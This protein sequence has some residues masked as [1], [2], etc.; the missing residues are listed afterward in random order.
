[1]TRHACAAVIAMLTV[2]TASV[3]EAGVQ[4]IPCRN[5][6]VF[7]N[8]AVNVVVLP[9]D[10]AE[11]LPDATGLGKRLSVLL[12]MEVLRSIAKFGSVGAVQMEGTPADCNPDLVIAKLLGRTPGAAATVAKGQGLIVV[13]GRFYSQGGDVFVQT[14]CR[15]MRS[16]IEE[17]FDV[18]MGGH[19]FSAAISAPVFACASWKVTKADLDNFESQFRKSTILRVKPEEAASGSPLPTQ[20]LPYWI[21]DT[22]GDWM[23]IS[24]QNGPQG[25]IQLSGARD[26]WSLARWLP[27]LR[28]VEGIAGYL[29]FRI[30]AQ[31]SAPVRPE[32]I[33][34]AMQAFLD[35]EASV[36]A[37][38]KDGTAGPAAALRNALAGAVQ[39]QLRGILSAAKPGATSDDRANALKFFERAE[40]ML[41]TDGNAR[42]LKAVAQVLLIGSG[43]PGV[44]LRQTAEDLLRAVSADPGNVRLLANLQ[45]AYEIL[46]AQAAPPLTDAER[47]GMEERLAAIK[48]IRTA[49]R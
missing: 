37:F 27:E 15:F 44:P 13:W 24:I 31:Q 22:Q 48:Q 29:R 33:A 16:G 14:Y 21:T 34:G 8:A 35:Y 32:W 9:Y 3:A 25:W 23:K 18:S 36:A 41:P 10:S 20:P 26:T 7:K 49:K 6:F 2:C 39:L 45:S 28:Y 43:S 11:A 4:N 19:R 46:L 17:T 5:P 47:A 38:G 40:A 42:N 1:M 12:Q 30:A